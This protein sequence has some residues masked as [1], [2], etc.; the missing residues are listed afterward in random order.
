MSSVLMI[1]PT[2]FFSDRGAH[3]RVL[4]SVLALQAK[5]NTVTLLTYPL[6]RDIAGIHTLRPFRL[7]GYSKNSPGFSWYKPLLDIILFVYAFAMLS[8]RSYGYIY[9]HLHE[10]ALIGICLKPFFHLK[11]VFDSQGS[12]TGELT[13]QQ[14]VRTGS[15][16]SRQLFKLE[17]W[18]TNYSDEIVTSTEGLAKFTRSLLTHHVPVRVVKDLPSR[19]LFNPNVIPV[20]YTL[21]KNKIIVLYL[22]GLQPYKGIDYLLDAIPHTSDQYHFLIMGYPIDYVQEKAAKLKI[23]NRITLTGKIP[24]EKAPSFLKL[25][26]IAVSPKTLESG[27]ANAKI[28][29]YLAMNLPVVCFEGPENRSILG[30][31][32]Y[33]AKHKDSRDLAETIMKVKV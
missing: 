2:P 16:M 19:H 26:Q 18:I 29:N 15:L 9:A 24:Y 13:A 23:E 3:V 12:L 4:N 33:Y 17:K 21:P 11:V 32:G 30:D 31:K 7:P 22:G 28:Y 1:A 10:G 6:G 20:V 5:G 14:T 27:E 8:K 25:G